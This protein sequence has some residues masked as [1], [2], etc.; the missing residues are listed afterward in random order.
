MESPKTPTKNSDG[1]YEILRSLSARWNLRFSERDPNWSPSKSPNRVDEEVKRRIRFLYFRTNTEA[2]E[3]A[4]DYFNN[5][6]SSRVLSEW[7]FKPHAEVDVIPQRVHMKSS[8]ATFIKRLE[9][10][11]SAAEDLMNYL[12]Q[13]IS[14]VADRVKLSKDYK[15]FEKSNH[16]A[17]WV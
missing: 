9:V 12:L 7:E 3:Y 16:Y 2:L 10:S 8:P 5:T 13:I 11:E 6:A 14:Q 15:V 4:L 1:L 17:L